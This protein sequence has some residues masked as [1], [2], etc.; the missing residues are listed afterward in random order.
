MNE[1]YSSSQVASILGISL[2]TFYRTR[3]WRHE[4][5]RLPRPISERGKLR[6]E[7][8]GTDAWFKRHHPLHPSAPANDLIALPDPV[9]DDEHRARLASAYGNRA[10]PANS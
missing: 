8:T 4:H 6:F 5:E 1:S 10:T 7:R 9:T 2:D 3:E